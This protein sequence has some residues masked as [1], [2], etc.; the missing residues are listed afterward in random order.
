MGRSRQRIKLSYARNTAGEIIPVHKADKHATYTCP[1]CEGEVFLRGGEGTQYVRHFVHAHKQ[2]GACGAAALHRVTKNSIKE[3][4]RENRPLFVQ[5]TCSGCHSVMRQPF[6]CDVTKGDVTIKAG[7]REDQD[8]PDLIVEGED[9]M[10]FVEVCYD[11]RL[12]T[13]KRERY[14]RRDI[15]WVECSTTLAMDWETRGL[16]IEG[17]V[18]S[19]QTNYCPDCEEK[20]SEKHQQKIDALQSVCSVAD[21]WSSS[22]SIELYSELICPEGESAVGDMIL[23]LGTNRTV[24]YVGSR[25]W[26]VPVLI[27]QY[28]E[29]YDALA[30]YDA[31]SSFERPDIEPLSEQVRNLNGRCRRI[32]LIELTNSTP[33]LVAYE[34]YDPDL[35]PLNYCDDHRADWTS[36]HELT[37]DLRSLIMNQPVMI[38]YCSR[39]GGRS[40]HHRFFEPPSSVKRMKY[41]TLKLKF[42]NLSCGDDKVDILEHRIVERVDITERTPSQVL[43]ENKGGVLFLRSRQ[44]ESAIL[45][46]EPNHDPGELGLYQCRKCYDD[47]KNRLIIKSRS[48]DLGKSS[49][50]LSGL[51]TRHLNNFDF[52]TRS[53]Y[54]RA[55]DK[56]DVMLVDGHKEKALN[57]NIFLGES[58][59]LNKLPKPV[60]YLDEIGG[61]TL[62]VHRQRGDITLQFE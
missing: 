61:D 9:R 47:T 23:N 56:A 13:T 35:P 52:I 45:C 33:E 24:A 25:G 31:D 58:G 2:S 36:K 46:T 42:A 41:D 7:T 39:C 55:P 3:T 40:R 48:P 18:G 32:G 54:D 4:V 14:R 6:F 38:R 50:R 19:F 8:L 28:D 37:E 51:E 16:V 43:D 30:L 29:T 17:L 62:V 1:E 59:S 26:F 21:Q 44:E 12:P 5:R 60:A 15:D 49:V 34:H 27:N 22:S 20:R 11:E 10:A 57:F 53:F